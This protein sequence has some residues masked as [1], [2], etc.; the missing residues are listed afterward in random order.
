MSDRPSHNLD[1]LDIDLARRIDEVCR[2][3]EA[4]WRKGRQP[5]VE[6]YLVDVPHEG[7]PALQAE[8]EALDRELRQSDETVARPEAIPATAT[9]PPT[10]PQPST[11]AEA[12]SPV[13][14]EATVPPSDPPGAPHEQPTAAAL[15]QDPSAAPDASELTRVRYFGDYELLHEIARGGM[16]VVYRARQIS[17]KRPV[18]L[19]MILAGQLAGEAEVRRFHLEAEAAANLDH[20]GIVPIYE[21][22]EH[23][24]QHFFSMG[25][26]E[27]TSLAAKVADGPLPPREAAELVRYVAEAV[28]YAHEKGVIHRDLKPAN[29]LL[30]SRGQPKVTDF[31]LA[32]KLQADSGLTHTGQVMGT[33]SYM[34]PEQANGRSVGPAADVYALGAILYCLLTGRPPFHAATPMDTLNQVVGQDPVPMRQLNASVPK[35]LETIGLKCLEKEPGKRYVSATALAEDLR[36]FLVDE[37][38]QARPV[39]QAE[40]AWRWCRRN[41]ALAGS[42]GAAA[43]ALVAVAV[44]AVLYAG[45]Q[46]RSRK[47]IAAIAKNLEKSLDESEALG[48][49]LQTSLATS[50]QRLA[51]LHFERG[52]IAL[53]KGQTGEGLLW[54]IETWRSAVA[55]GDPG[56]QHTARANLAAW[57]SHHIGLKAVFSHKHWVVDVA[58]SPDGKAVITGSHDNTARLWDAATGEPIGA[59]LAHKDAVRA[60]AFSPNSKAV[61]TG[62]DDNT[63]RLWDATTGEPI[64]PPLAHKGW[65]RAVA[66]SPN[67][68]AVITGSDDNTARLWDAATG[69]PIGPPLAHKGFVRAMAF[70]PDGK[71]VLTGSQ[72]NTARL[73]DAATGKP[74]GPP[75]EHQNW[76][77]AVAFSPDGKAVLTGSWDNTARLWDAATSKPIGPPLEHQNWVMAVA[78]SPDGKAVLTGSWDNTARLWDAATGKPIGP[79]LTHK[80]FVRAVAFSP[81]SKVVITGGNDKTARLWDAATGRPIGSPLAHPGFVLAVAFSPDGKAVLTGSDDKTA[82]LRDAATDKPI[83]RPLAHQGAVRAVAFSPD[84]KA[85][86]TGSEDRMARL[87]DAATGKPSA[88]PLEHKDQVWAVAF[89]PDGKAV[90]TGSQDNTARLWD[91]ATGKPIGSPLEHQ[92]GVSAETCRQARRLLGIGSPLEHRVRAV[93]FS[94]DGKAVLTG[95]E[96][97]TARLWDA[98]TGQPIGPPLAHQGRVSAVAFSPDGIAVIT[99]SDDNTARLWDAATGQPIGPALAHKGFVWAVAFSPDGKA[100]LTGSQDKTARLWD[101]AT[102]QPIGPPLEHQ[103]AVSAVAFSPDGKAVLTG[104]W[105]KTA[106]LWDAATGEP[107]GPPLEH[108]GVVRAVAFSSDGKAVLTGSEDSTARLWDTA[109]GEPIG[110]P[111]EHQEVVTAVAFSP[112]GKAVLT[113]S[114]DKTARVWTITELPDDLPRLT[115]WVELV[116]G[117]ELD[118]QGSV[119]TL[120]NAAWRQ[121]RERLDREGGP[122]E[123]DRR[124]RLDP[125]LF[126]PEPTARAGLDRARAVDGGRDRLQR[127]R[128][129]EAVRFRR[130]ARTRPLSLRSFPARQGRR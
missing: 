100:V 105:D 24:G 53:E 116:T 57:Q 122:P 18:A 71:A 92:G 91:A 117:L 95:S 49:K 127:G 121:R 96:D 30:D 3:F 74:I 21:I 67:S 119:R 44:L 103:D 42:L 87:W 1:G 113:G 108:K 7:R 130:S 129:G 60:V 115:S 88:P 102:G 16:G 85:V 25:F 50:N 45:G 62:S 20:P 54:M 11:N 12:V 2:R 8:L 61:I 89:S 98:A 104:S 13:D 39:G 86:L 68:K 38:I 101:A 112:D 82:R 97:R 26:V 40:R 56:W 34:P 43:A 47:A 109:T 63:A 120:D 6:D 52:R 64:G 114:D 31:G 72:D 15:G 73:W 41:P 4:D 51:A 99:G 65:V 9:E 14:E 126:G 124:W 79:P 32:K 75:L 110:P 81:N 90:I 28:Q 77:M 17:L 118:G 66:F 125:I 59:P 35:D 19:K 106:R 37:P 94:P 76:V 111:L 69:K 123:T 10:A 78:F 93:V 46:A 29:V 22:G 80:G 70:S 5:V 107:I 55:A 36:R 23:E 27:G 128:P 58:F 33:P 48:Q 83:G 84:G